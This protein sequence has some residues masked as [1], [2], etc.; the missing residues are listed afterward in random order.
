[1]QRALSI[2]A[3]VA[4][5]VLSAV[6]AFRG[7]APGGAVASSP[8]APVFD[9]GAVAADAATA[10]GVVDAAHPGLPD[11]PGPPDL[12]DLAPVDVPPGGFHLADG[13]P[14][15]P[16]GKGTPRHVRFGVVLVT[17]EGAEGAPD[18]GARRKPDALALATKLADEAKGD[19]RATVQRGD[20]GS[21]DDVG[22]V[23]RGVLEPAPEAVLF[24]LP[25][26]GVSGAI[27][28]PRGFWIVKR[29]E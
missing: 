1:M 13:T 16:L 7:A 8:A 29:L 2:A 4:A 14:V 22:E 15:P 24:A 26:G 20:V 17:Y 25:V 28:T 12:P 19:F 23:A 5:V 10:T 6:L 11:L 18:K 9:G 21:T 27:D 3:S